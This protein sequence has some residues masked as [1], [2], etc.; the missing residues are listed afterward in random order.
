MAA[1]TFK[2]DVL[3][4]FK[5]SYKNK[6]QHLCR[7]Q[8]AVA[9]PLPVR[10]SSCFPSS[11]PACVSELCS[12]SGYH[13]SR[14]ASINSRH[15][16]SLRWSEFNRSINYSKTMV[17]APTLHA[18]SSLNAPCWK[19]FSHPSSLSE[20]VYV[21]SRIWFA[22]GL[23]QFFCIDIYMQLSSFVDCIWR[24]FQLLLWKCGWSWRETIPPNHRCKEEQQARRFYS[25]SFW[26]QFLKF[27]LQ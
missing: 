10:T 2:L 14:H 11:F 13:A 22:A 21:S 27:T 18:H 26:A 20:A 12:A 24:T 5:T 3:N 15:M 23:I 1:G 16:Y 25:R 8:A 19:R 7:G 17:L 9:N 4:L 6:V